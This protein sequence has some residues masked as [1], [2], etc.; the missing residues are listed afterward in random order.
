MVKAALARQSTENSDS[1]CRGRH[2][3]LSA[4]WRRSDPHACPV[5][6][7]SYDFGPEKLPGR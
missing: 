1:P 5:F 7:I 4:K 2:G 3:L 6:C